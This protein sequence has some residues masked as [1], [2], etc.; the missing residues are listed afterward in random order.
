MITKNN[1][2]TVLGTL[3]FIPFND[4][5]D[6]YFYEYENNAKITVNFKKNKIEL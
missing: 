1:L 6:I 3:G 2:K 4:N 5:H